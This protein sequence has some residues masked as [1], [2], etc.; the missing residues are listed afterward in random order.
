M[1]HIFSYILKD[2]ASNFGLI[3]L[4]ALGVLLMFFI[5]WRCD[6][7]GVEKAERFK[8]RARA[9]AND[10]NICPQLVK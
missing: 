10:G 8:E 6:G 3:S 7:L 1:I 4:S 5:N 9:R 2:P